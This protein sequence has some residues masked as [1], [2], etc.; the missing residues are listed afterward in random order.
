MKNATLF[1]GGIFMEKTEKL[2]RRG[3]LNPNKT[4]YL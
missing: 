3:E 4:A 1:R 2:W